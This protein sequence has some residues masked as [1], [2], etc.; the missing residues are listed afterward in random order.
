MLLTGLS[1]ETRDQVIRVLF[2]HFLAREFY[3]PQALSNKIIEQFCCM[4]NSVCV[5]NSAYFQ[6][7][8]LL[9]S[10]DR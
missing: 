2:S 10:D 1:G 7:A 3:E 6:A 4:N 9:Y 5:R 8:N